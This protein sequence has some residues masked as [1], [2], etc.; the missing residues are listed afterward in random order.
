MNKRKLMAITT[1]ILSLGSTL[2]FVGNGCSGQFQVDQSSLGFAS[3]DGL[4]GILGTPTEPDFV[5]NAKTVSVAYSQQALDQMASCLGVKTPSD[6][7]LRMYDTKK[8]A[9]SVYGSAETI[10]SPMMMSIVS[11][12]GELCNDL[13]NQE[14]APASQRIF[15]GWDMASSATPSQGL[16]NEAVSRMALSCWQRAETSGER[17][18]I[19]DTLSSVAANE[20]RASEKSALILCTSMISSLNSLLN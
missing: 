5:A 10:T 11:I 16:I 3:S 17:Q 18:E 15:K 2:V 6:A 19:I 4:S 7:T 8:G 13:I 9:I 20:V 1:V 14:R 12:G